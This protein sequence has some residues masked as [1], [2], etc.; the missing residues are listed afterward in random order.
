VRTVIDSADIF[1]LVSRTEGLPRA[2]IEAMARGLPCI[3]TSVG[4]IPELLEPEDLIPPGDI[5]ALV[6][7]VTEM[8]TSPDRL[9]LAGSRNLRRSHDYAT[10][11]LRRRREAMMRQLRNETEHWQAARARHSA[12]RSEV[13]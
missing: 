1:L 6:A 4:G 5:E 2:L 13:A 7:K 9:A 12:I 10:E 11:P 3:G 8:A